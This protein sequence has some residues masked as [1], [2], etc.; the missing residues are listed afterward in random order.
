[1]VTQK[2]QSTEWDLI[3]CDE[4]HKM[5]ATFSGGEIIRTKRFNLGVLLSGITRHFLLLTA[6]PHNGKEEDF[7]LFLSLIDNDRFEG[8][9]RS[10]IHSSDVSDLMRRMVKED[11]VTFDGKPLFPERNAYTVEYELTDM[12][13][14]LYD[15][16]TEYVRQEFNRAEKLLSDGRKNNIGF[17]LTIL[18]RRLASSPEAIYQSLVRRKK[19]LEDLLS[20]IEK[21]K[22]DDINETI[23]SWK[24]GVAR[25]LKKYIPN[26]TWAEDAKCGECGSD[27]VVYQEG[28]LTCLSC[29]SS[30]CG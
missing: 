12:E 19:K 13:L 27:D 3:V 5:S 16:V 15:R 20:S 26:G 17:A 4:A 30:K 14:D 8:K 2:L 9:F 1:L 6:T 28:C 23:N 21:N 11:L 10:G 29:G 22:P 24:A 7:Q 25:A 18:Q